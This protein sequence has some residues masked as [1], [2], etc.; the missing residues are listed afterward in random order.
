MNS[1]IKPCLPLV[2]SS[3][4]FVSSFSAMSRLLQ[5]ILFNHPN[6]ITHTNR[7]DIRY[8]LLSIPD[9]TQTMERV[10]VLWL[11]LLSFLPVLQL[12]Q[13]WQYYSKSPSPKPWGPPAKCSLIV[14]PSQARQAC[15]DHTRQV[16]WHCRPLLTWFL[17]QV[18]SVFPWLTNHRVV[19]LHTILH[20][21]ATTSIQKGPHSVFSPNTIS[22]L[23]VQTEDD[24][25]LPY[26]T[27]SQCCV[28]SHVVGT[29][30]R[31]VNL[32]FNRWS[33]C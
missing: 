32:C 9:T 27:R 1:P 23:T 10:C 22:H 28:H 12:F 21:S 26:C 13:T 7:G 8:T 11:R 14:Q 3:H 33:S 18:C 29:S 25:S 31:S 2:F 16:S 24:R 19:T 20:I 5:S 6:N 17:A 30:F 15:H 4:N